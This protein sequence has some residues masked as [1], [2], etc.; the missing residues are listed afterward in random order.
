MAYKHQSESE[1]KMKQARTYIFKH[2][3]TG[4]IE[5]FNDLQMAKSIV[6]SPTWQP[7][8]Q[9]TKDLH[10]KQKAAEEAK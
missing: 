1:I 9:K 5:G 4:E 8:N 6:T 7:Q 10:K 2:K 3:N